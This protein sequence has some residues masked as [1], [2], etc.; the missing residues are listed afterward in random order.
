MSRRPIILVLLLSLLSPLFG[1]VTATYKAKP[2]LHF[3]LFDDVYQQRYGGIGGNHFAGK[4]VTHIGSFEIETGGETVR[5]LSLNSSHDYNFYFKGPHIKNP[6]ASF[7]FFLGSIVKYGN[8][9]WETYLNKGARNPIEPMGH[10]MTGTITVDFYLVSWEG[11]S[12]FV[13]DG[14]Y[15]HTSGNLP[16]FSVAFSTGG[17]YWNASFDPMSVNGGVPGQSL[18]YF[19]D[20][21]DTFPDEEIDYGDPPELFSYNFTIKDEQAI[22]LSDAFGSNKAQVAKAEMMVVNGTPFKTYGVEVLFTTLDQSSTFEM[23]RVGMPSAT[24]IP[25]TLL[26]GNE[27]VEPGMV[28]DWDGLK[29]GQMAARAIQVTNISQHATST[30][31]SGTYRDTIYINITPK[32]TV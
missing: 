21:S 15:T 19:H 5:N 25:Y 27:E 16:P 29:N 17:D 14:S 7:G 12:V 6:E 1:A 8:S 2:V 22:T 3:E 32:D 24:T 4:L 23:K 11:A 28:I 26:F 20:G 30:L 31:L 10:P 18:P 9:L 13:K